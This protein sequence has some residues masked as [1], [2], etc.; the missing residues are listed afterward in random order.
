[1]LL[2]IDPIDA[3]SLFLELFVSL[4][5]NCFPIT[6]LKWKNKLTTSMWGHVINVTA[7]GIIANASVVAC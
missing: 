1:M 5:E 6:R 2:V 3:P 4:I 7:Y